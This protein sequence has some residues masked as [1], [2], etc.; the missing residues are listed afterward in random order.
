MTRCSQFLAAT[1]LA[2]CWL[3]GASRAGAQPTVGQIDTFTSGTQGWGS[4]PG[5]NPNPPIQ[6]TTGGL[7]P[8]DPFLLIR[9]SGLEGPG[10]RLVAINGSQWAGNYLGSGIGSITMDVNNFGPSDLYLRLLFADALGGPPTNIAISLNPI[11]LPAASGWM[12][13]TFPIIPSG[14]GALLGTVNGALSNA[15][16]MRI[17]NNQAFDF[18]GP[19]I[20]IPLVNAMLGVDN[21][22]AVATPEPATLVLVLS[23]ALA[24]VPFRRRLRR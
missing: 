24:L 11:F 14:L 18:P 15:T 3:A 4:G 22:T 13:V 10:G 7:S 5:G 8:T 9:S 23:G 19:G 6:S 20:G 21:I 1:L 12:S 17:F 16:E 2:A